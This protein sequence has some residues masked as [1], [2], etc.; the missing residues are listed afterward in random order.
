VPL[1]EAAGNAFL[2][3]IQKFCDAR[4]DY[5]A[6]GDADCEGAKFAL[7]MSALAAE[8]TKDIVLAARH[9]AGTLI[10]VVQHMP[11]YMTV[12]TLSVHRTL[13]DHFAHAWLSM[14]PCGYCLCN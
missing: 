12:R 11:T 8:W 3:A 5:I 9:E 6:I 2:S 4:L 10:S 7:R 14:G 1:Q 13:S